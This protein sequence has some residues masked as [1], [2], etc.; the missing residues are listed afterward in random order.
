[1]K[2]LTNQ[3]KQLLVLGGLCALC[4]ASAAGYLLV[5]IRL[6]GA[7]LEEEMRARVAREQRAEETVRH[8]QLLEQTEKP[9]SELA[10]AFLTSENDGIELL[11]TIETEAPK[12]GLTLTDSFIER[13][14]DPQKP[15]QG[16]IVMRFSY[17]GAK[18]TVYD[19]SRML[20]TMPMQARVEKLQL[21]QEGEQWKAQV[22]IRITLRTS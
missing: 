19:F 17:A 3:S 7:R 14:A 6:S 2:T 11:N 15:D 16:E 8:S 21:T 18:A 20:E 5:D 12:A 9:R 1:M 4:A 22:E 13:V 10:S